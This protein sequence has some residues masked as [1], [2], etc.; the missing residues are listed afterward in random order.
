MQLL[1]VFSSSIILEMDYV[2]LRFIQNILFGEWVFSPSLCLTV[3]FNS[4]SS[5]S[6]FVHMFVKLVLTAYCGLDALLGPQVE[7]LALTSIRPNPHLTAKG[8][9][10]GLG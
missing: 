2:L 1:A 10:V 5:L 4:A 9:I 8:N 7:Q 6:K 3:C